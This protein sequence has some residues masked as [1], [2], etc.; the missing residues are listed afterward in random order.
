MKKIDFILDQETGWITITNDGYCI[1]VEKSEY[2]YE[3]YR[4]GKV[5]TEKLYPAEIFFGE[6]SSFFLLS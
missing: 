4:T 5:I 1:P 6:M 2:D 3:D